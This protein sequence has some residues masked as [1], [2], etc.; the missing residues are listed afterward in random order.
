[1]STAILAIDQ[2]T[3]STKALVVGEN[4][5][6]V[7]EAEVAVHPVAGDDGS[8]E[9]D[10]EEL[11]QSVVEAGRA[12]LAQADRRGARV[13]AVGLANQGETVL[14]WDPETGVPFSRALVWQDRRAASVCE[15]LAADGWGPRLR[16]L[17]GLELDPYF[18]APKLAWLREHV[19]TAG[20]AGTTDTWLVRRLTGAYVTDAATASRS[21]LLDLDTGTWSDEACGA[22]AIDPAD[23]PDIVDCAGPVGETDAFG[24]TLQLTGLAVDQQA[25]LFAE[26]CFATG[27]VK[28]TY[29]TGAFLL[30][31]TGATPRRSHNGLVSCI[32]WRLDG[33]STYC[34][35][36]QVYTVG[37]AVGW[38]REIGLVAE[39][40]DLDRV[41]G[42][43]ASAGGVVFVPGLAGL[44]APFWAPHAKGAFTGLTLATTRAHLVRAVAEGIAAQVAWLAR[45]AAEDLGAPLTRLRVDGGLTRSRTLLQL[46]ADLAQVPVEVYPSPH[47]TA[48]GVAAFARLGAGGATSPSDA[49]GPWKPTA[50]YEPAIDPAPADELLAAWRA[51]AEATLGLP[52]RDPSAP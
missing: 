46:Q 28:C 16:E 26:S 50:V 3:S 43:V 32:A 15:R 25:A 51:A 52:H 9:V 4:G 48:L 14:A 1:M 44:G 12:A 42:S 37:A 49:V 47:A 31:N 24:P 2:G 39:P 8:V 35:D 40:A 41:G 11:W 33:V 18:V 13:T 36:G 5:S 22:F 23:L 7:S 10:P 27:D 19:T 34:L 38:L 17:T 29:G 6:V 20:T 30:A 45:A 21:L